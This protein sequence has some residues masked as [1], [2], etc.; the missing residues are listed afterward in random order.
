MGKQQ[1]SQRGLE[2]GSKGRYGQ[3][4]QYHWEA[5]EA[6]SVRRALDFPLGGNGDLSKDRLGQG[7]PIPGPQTSTHLWPLRNRATQKEV[8]VR[9]A[10]EGTSKASSV[11]AA[12]PQH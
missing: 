5:E 11:C 2:T 6:G 10:S 12:A 4:H 3:K 9:Q 7:S 1:Q 8:S